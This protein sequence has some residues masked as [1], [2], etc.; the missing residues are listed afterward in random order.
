MKRCAA[1]LF[2]ALLMCLAALPVNGAGYT[3]N[4]EGKAAASPDAFQGAKGI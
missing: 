3:Y 1:I 4:S 2:V